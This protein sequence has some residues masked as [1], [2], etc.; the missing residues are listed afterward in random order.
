M[1]CGKTTL[2]ARVS[3][4]ENAGACVPGRASAA[5]G[6]RAT[7]SSEASDEERARVLFMSRWYAKAGSC[8]RCLRAAAAPPSPGADVVA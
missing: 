6:E 7:S 8:A 3:H 1:N 4:V 2:E 5:P